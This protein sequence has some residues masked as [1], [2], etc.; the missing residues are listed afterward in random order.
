VAVAGRTY[1]LFYCHDIDNGTWVKLTDVPA[2][3]TGEGEISDP[4]A[5][6]AT[7]RFYRLATP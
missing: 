1:T 3:A 6:A 2:A 4:G 5:N 7:T